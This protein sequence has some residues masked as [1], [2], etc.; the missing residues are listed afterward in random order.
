MSLNNRIKK[1]E[2]ALS[3]GEGR[4]PQFIIIGAKNTG[5]IH[6]Y[7]YM[8]SLRTAVTASEGISID[9]MPD[10]D[11]GDFVDRAKKMIAPTIAPNCAGILFAEYRLLEPVS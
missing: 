3:I 10:E 9:R 11:S 5:G 2:D 1:L 4:E 7:S 6:D 8:V